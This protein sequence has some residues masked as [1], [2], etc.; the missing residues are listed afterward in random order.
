MDCG[1]KTTFAFLTE[2]SVSIF[3]RNKIRL[4]KKTLLFNYLAIR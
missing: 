1:L 2:N 3:F 4:P